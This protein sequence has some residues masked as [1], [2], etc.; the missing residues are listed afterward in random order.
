KIPKKG[1]ESRS[2]AIGILSAKVHEMQTSDKMKQ[3]IDELKNKTDD[4][5]IQKAVEECELDYERNHKI[6]QAEYKEYVTL[7][8]Q[9]EAAWQEARE[10]ADFQLFQPYLEK[11]VE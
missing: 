3:F 2:K 8:G 11:L 5:V 1:V 7:Q 9:A 6:P 10:K 4:E